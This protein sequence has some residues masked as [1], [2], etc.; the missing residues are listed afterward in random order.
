MNQ[1]EF[2]QLKLETRE[3]FIN[4]GIH[5]KDLEGHNTIEQAIIE[6]VDIDKLDWVDPKYL[7]RATSKKE[8]KEVRFE[9]T[10][11][12]VLFPRADR[13]L[14]TKMVSYDYKHPEKNIDGE[15]AD[16]RNYCRFD[17]M[18]EYRVIDL[19]LKLYIG[20]NHDSW[21]HHSLITEDGHI[22]ADFHD[23]QLPERMKKEDFYQLLVNHVAKHPMLLEVLPEEIF[24]DN[25]KIADRFY[26]LYLIITSEKIKEFRDEKQMDE[27]M[28][29][30]KKS[31][32]YI[33]EVLNQRLAQ[34]ELTAK[35]EQI[36]LEKA[37]KHNK[38]FQEKK[39]KYSTDV[40]TM[41]PRKRDDKTKE[42]S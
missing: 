40:K 37:K 15:Y 32:E 25:P 5:Q 4:H 27:F 22:I 20:R 24:I 9:K 14:P 8:A 6:G 19:P 21:A 41:F 38:A 26:D 23:K 16:Y 28:T 10:R 7:K 29:G 12:F 39:A 1:E 2:E 36:E 13:S 34:A 11:K 30:V 18:S 35:T 33:N 31:T 42:N 3:F 17:S